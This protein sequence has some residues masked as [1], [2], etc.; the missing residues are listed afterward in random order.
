MGNLPPYRANR[1]LLGWCTLS[2]TIAD[3][4]RRSAFL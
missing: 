1:S 2:G 4:I 3:G